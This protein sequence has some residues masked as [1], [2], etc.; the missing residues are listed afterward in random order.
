MYIYIYAYM[1]SYCR[2]THYPKYDD[3]V[4]SKLL[5][6][7]E[8]RNFRSCCL[9]G[10][11]VIC[12]VKNARNLATTPKGNNFGINFGSC[13]LSGFG[14]KG[15]GSHICVILTESTKSLFLLSRRQRDTFFPLAPKQQNTTNQRNS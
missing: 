10:L 11:R 1:Y 14:Q 13:F 9:Q 15:L 6:P 4:C 8:Q 5:L 12:S 2:E 3:D 7:Q